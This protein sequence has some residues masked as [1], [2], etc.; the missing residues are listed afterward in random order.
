MLRDRSDL[1]LAVLPALSL[2]S[3][4]TFHL[5]LVCQKFVLIHVAVT[6]GVFTGS[7]FHGF[8]PGY[9]NNSG[10]EVLKGIFR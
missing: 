8:A 6:D 10:I 4:L 2:L 3:P 5:S 1:F 9:F 7:L